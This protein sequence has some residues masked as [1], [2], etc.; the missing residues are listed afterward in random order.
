[1]SAVGSKGSWRG[2]LAVRIVLPG[3]VT[4]QVS[5]VGLQSDCGHNEGE[6][7]SGSGGRGG[8][9]IPAL[10]VQLSQ[11]CVS[12]SWGMEQCWIQ[13]WTSASS[14]LCSWVNQGCSGCS[15]CSFSLSSASTSDCSLRR[16]W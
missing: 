9:G 6:E 4:Y 1:M 14:S 10:E 15:R 8:G 2:W 11:P 16:I 12:I 7:L 5:S 13:G 3:M